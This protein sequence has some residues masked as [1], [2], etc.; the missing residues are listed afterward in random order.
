MINLIDSS[1]TGVSNSDNLTNDNTPTVSISTEPNTHL[2]ITLTDAN[3]IVSTFDGISDNDGVYTWNSDDSLSDGSYTISAVAVDASGNESDSSDGFTMTIDTVAP[4]ASIDVD[5]VSADGI[6]NS[7]ESNSDITITGRVSQDVKVGD[8]VT[9]KLDGNNISSSSVTQGSNGALVYSI[10]VAGS[11][12]ASA[13]SNELTV[14]V[15]TSDDAGNETIVA[16]SE[17]YVVDTTNNVDLSVTDGNEN[18]N[19][20][21][22]NSSE[23]NSINING[24]LDQDATMT[25]LSV[26]DGVTTLDLDIDNDLVINND[27]SYSIDADV[28]SLNDGDLSVIATSKDDAGNV[29]SETKEISKDTTF[30]DG[31]QDTGNLSIENLVDTNGDYSD[32]V[33]SGNGVIAGDTIK[34]YDED[35]NVV[36]DANENPIEVT[37]EADLTWSVNISDLP[38]TR[39][40][41]NEFFH[42][43]E[44]DSEGNFVSTTNTHYWH[45]TYNPATI[46]ATDDFVFTGSGDDTIKIQVDDVNDKVMVD[47]GNGEDTALFDGNASDYT[48]LTDANGYTIVTENNGSNDVNEL[49]NIEVIKFADQEY[50]TVTQNFTPIAGDDTYDSSASNSWLSLDE[51]SSSTILASNLLAND[52]DFDGNSLSIVNVNS[53]SDTHGSVALDK[54]GNIMFTP[55]ANYSGTASFTYSVVDQDGVTSNEATVSMFVRAV[56]DKPSLI[57]ILNDNVDDSNANE[58]NN[59]VDTAIEIERGAFGLVGDADNANVK[60]SSLATAKFIGQIVDVEGDGNVANFEGHDK[61]WLKVELKEGETLILDVDHGNASRSEGTIYNVEGS[62]DTVVSVYELNSNGDATLSSMQ[63]HLYNRD[64]NT[65]D[66]TNDDDHLDVNNMLQ[67]G[68]GSEVY[69]TDAQDNGNGRTLDAYM[70]FEAPKDGTYFVEVSA[71]NNHHGN[72]ADSGTYDLYLSI[73]NPASD[74]VDQINANNETYTYDSLTIDAGSGDDILVVNDT[75]DFASLVQNVDNVETISLSDGVHLD[76]INALDVLDITDSNNTLEIVGNGDIDMIDTNEWI[77]NAVESDAS[78]TQ[79]ESMVN[80]ET[81]TLIVDNQVLPDHH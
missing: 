18:D 75:I 47:G 72:A 65:T 59:V 68:D 56:E 17:V 52:S 5:V 3:G 50:S 27:G 40:N 57:T 69:Y 1:D 48:I 71:F 31:T 30:G 63:D 21:I 9:L 32:I 45:G 33:I 80:N 74:I 39:V 60:D 6:I 79:Y 78:H 38:N 76:A 67:G 24:T 64:G 14:E 10:V 46:E 41:D 77:E 16:S 70:E 36:V 25:S 73:D 81:I 13:N 61:D 51:D 34:L 42:I 43:E 8:T 37:V 4:E 29:T 55:D 28:S 62:V 44:F 22:I 26:S 11:V 49:R 58:T 20:N 12:L 35:N 53:S 23:D 66:A 2:D 54:D 15:S 19:D 7:V